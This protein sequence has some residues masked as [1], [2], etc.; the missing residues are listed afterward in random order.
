MHVYGLYLLH[1]A[2]YSQFYVYICDF[3]VTMATGSVWANLS[4]TLKCVHSEYPLIG[5]RIW[6]ICDIMCHT[7]W[8][9]AIFVLKFANFLS[10]LNRPSPRT[11]Y[12]V[13]VR[14][15]RSHLLCKASYSQFCQN[16]RFFVT[17]LPWQQGRSEEI[18]LTP[19]NVRTLNTQACRG[20][21]YE[22]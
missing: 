7:T 1:K 5:A 8:V 10:P 16:S 15:Y 14:L 9:I 3:F 21:G 2:S 18:R 11:P 4:D 17:N 22:T 19:S 6:V 13:Q 20:N 12:W